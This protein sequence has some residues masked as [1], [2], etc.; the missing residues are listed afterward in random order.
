MIQ[1]LFNKKIFLL[2]SIVAACSYS[3]YWHNNKVKEFK[4]DVITS[5]NQEISKQTKEKIIKEET[6]KVKIATE[7][8]DRVV[9]VQ[10]KIEEFN[11]KIDS[12]KVD[13]D[14]NN[15]YKGL[16]ECLESC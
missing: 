9:I 4:S 15:T 5:I 11:N 1:L 2:V 3:Y 10:E 14:I 8:K 6:V 13:D 16:L 7:Y 12:T